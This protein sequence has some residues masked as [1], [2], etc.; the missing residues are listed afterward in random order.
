VLYGSVG[1][2]RWQG[3]GLDED[4]IPTADDTTLNIIPLTLQAGYRADFIVKYTPVPLVPYVRG[5]LAY[6][7]YWVTDGNG[8]LGRVENPDGD[9]FVGQGGK[10]G[11]VGTAGVALLLNFFDVR[12]TR[13]L[14]NST[15]IRGT[16]LFFEGMIADVNGFGQEGFDFSD[17]S[18]NAGLSMEW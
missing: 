14:Y 10:F 16:Y 6:Y 9:D 17:L 11:V 15:G 12:S 13:S 18:W 4:R 3:S 5:G 7:I 8:E 2:A 1:F